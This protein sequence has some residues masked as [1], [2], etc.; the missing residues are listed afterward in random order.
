MNGFAFYEPGFDH[1]IAINSGKLKTTGAGNG[2]ANTGLYPVLDGLRAAQRSWAGQGNKNVLVAKF[3]KRLL[4]QDSFP[5]KAGKKQN[6]NR[7][8]LFSIIA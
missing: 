1:L 5:D 7:N 3:L 2:K 4:V 6:I 8:T